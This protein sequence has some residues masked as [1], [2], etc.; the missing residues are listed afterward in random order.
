MSKISSEAF[1]IEKPVNIDNIDGKYQK[2]FFSEI[3]D[4][5]TY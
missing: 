3:A 4:D 5:V 2:F 1:E